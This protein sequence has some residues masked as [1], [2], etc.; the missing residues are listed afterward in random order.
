MSMSTSR[1][2]ST[3]VSTFR[4]TARTSTTSSTTPLAPS[5]RPGNTV[6][7]ARMTAPTLTP[8]GGGD[9]GSSGRDDGA[10]PPVPHLVVRSHEGAVAMPL[11]ATGVLVIGRHDDA[12]VRLSDPRA[13]RFHAQL[14]VGEGFM[15]RDLGSANGVRIRDQRLPPH[16]TVPLQLGDPVTI[17]D[18]VLSVEWRKPGFEARRV[19]AH[20]YLETR[21]VEE[22]ARAQD[23]GAPLGLARLHADERAPAAKVERILRQV[24]RGGDLLA[25]YAPHEYEALLVDADEAT[26]QGLTDAMVAALAA[27]GI[28]ARAALACYPGDGSSPQ[29]LISVACD[30]LAGISA[31][32]PGAAVMDSKPMRELNAVARRAALSAK[33]VL[34][35]GEAGSGKHLLAESIHRLSR[36]GDQPFVSLDGAAFAERRLEAELFGDEGETGAGAARVGALEAASGGTLFLEGLAQMPPSIQ[37]RLLAALEQGEIVRQGATKPRPIDVRCV[38]ASSRPL[39]EEV[40]EGRVNQEL[41]R[42]LAGFTLDLPPLR[43]RAEDVAGLARLFLGRFAGPGRSPPALSPEALALMRS[44]SWPGNVRELRNMIERAALLCERHTITEENLPAA[45]MRRS[46]WP[47]VPALVTMPIQ[48]AAAG[49]ASGRSLDQRDRQALIDALRRCHGNPIRAAELLHMPPRRFR[50]LMTQLK[51]SPTGE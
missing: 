39:A 48:R 50:E 20:A 33:N 38:A 40:A 26:A 13:S 36:R 11:P 42:R 8:P 49:A 18:T 4:Y 5:A 44:Y 35:V 1:S 22:C 21:L 9:D 6:S 41:A 7:G 23:R 25:V 12:D 3:S 27:Q 43:E 24:A 34:I 47:I 51:V 32:G 17:G 14:E 37:V 30:R 29:E 19:W 31:P 46:A 28:A 15:L 16:G 10:A 2:A 45:R